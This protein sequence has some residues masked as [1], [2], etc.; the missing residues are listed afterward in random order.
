MRLFMLTAMIVG[1]A[2]IALAD[3]GT[4][5]VVWVETSFATEGPLSLFSAPDGNGNTFTA[6]YAP[7]GAIVDGTL[8]M[9]LYVDAGTSSGPVPDF[10]WEDI[11]LDST[12]GALVACSGG[13]CPD[14]N[15]DNNGETRWATT[16]EVG[17]VS[18]PDL[19]HQVRIIVN[20]GVPDSGGLLPDLRLNSADI[21]GDLEVNLSDIQEFAEDFYGAYDYRSDFVW[22]GLVNLSDLA[23]L[24]PVFGAG[25]P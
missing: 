3:S 20:G 12:G 18:D 9:I 2:A 24:A 4:I 23:A 16:L 15:T 19:G 5:P 17:G 11:W 13:S 8:T 1:I 14:E 22:D 7:G 25:C 21:T 10:P 6:A